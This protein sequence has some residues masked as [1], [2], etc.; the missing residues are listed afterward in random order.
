MLPLVKLAGIAAG[1][2]LSLNVL[3]K[4]FG[5]DPDFM[6][7]YMINRMSGQ[8]GFFKTYFSDGLRS[9]FLGSRT[10]SAMMGSGCFCGGL[11]GPMMGMNPYMMNPAMMGGLPYGPMG[12]GRMMWGL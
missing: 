3:G 11:Y 1:S 6:Q 2:L 8:G 7:A 10:A 4:A 9:L 12:M 5:R